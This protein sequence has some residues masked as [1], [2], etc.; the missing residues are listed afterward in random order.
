VT[1]LLDTHALLWWLAD[2]PQLPSL[3]REA[4]RGP[5]EPVYVSAVSAWEIAVKRALGKLEVPEEWVSA[6]DEDGFERLEITWDHVLELGELPDV[7][8]DPF[9]RLL[10]AQARVEGM[11]L[12]TG[13]ARIAGYGTP[14]LWSGEER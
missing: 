5:R 6:V 10:V 4:I 8:R 14:V 3:A 1:L 9:D 2:D 11:T 13:D 12:V 7:H